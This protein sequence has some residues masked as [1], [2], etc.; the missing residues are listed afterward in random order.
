[1]GIFHLPAYTSAMSVTVATATASTVASTTAFICTCGS[2]VSVLSTTIVNGLSLVV[3]AA[4]LSVAEGYRGSDQ[5]LF[6]YRKSA[7]SSL[8]ISCCILLTSFV[9]TESTSA[10]TRS[11]GNFRSW[12]LSGSITLDCT[13]RSPVDD[14]HRWLG[15]LVRV[16]IVIIAYVPI[17]V[18][19]VVKLSYLIEQV[20]SYR[21]AR[22][23]SKLRGSALVSRKSIGRSS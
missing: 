16:F 14:L 5:Q 18:S 12:S 22:K 15:F 2:W 23:G 7:N 19:R 6:C 3:G 11:G 10:S 17:A 21:E 1:M 9:S 13:G 8:R 20:S 4:G